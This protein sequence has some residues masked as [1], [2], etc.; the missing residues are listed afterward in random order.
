MLLFF[1]PTKMW[2]SVFGLYVP[3][4]KFVENVLSPCVKYVSLKIAYLRSFARH[5]IFDLFANVW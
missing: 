4:G 5:I 1:F 3:F 2:L